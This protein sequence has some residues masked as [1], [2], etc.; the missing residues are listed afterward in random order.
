MQIFSR[1]IG[2]GVIISSEVEIFY[3]VRSY[4]TPEKMGMSP[5]SKR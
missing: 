2:F 5:N 3:V 1:N 4:A